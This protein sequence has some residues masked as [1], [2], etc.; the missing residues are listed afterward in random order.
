[1]EEELG[2]ELVQELELEV[3]QVQQRR[4]SHLKQPQGFRICHRQLMQSWQQGGIKS[5]KPLCALPR[6]NVCHRLCLLAC[7][8]GC[9]LY[10]TTHPV[11]VCARARQHTKQSA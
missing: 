6:Q 7:L 5:V 10:P 1:M 2:Q 8:L 4:Q 3:V 9:L 11:S